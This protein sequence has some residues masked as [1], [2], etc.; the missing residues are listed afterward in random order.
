MLHPGD[1]SGFSASAYYD[2][3]QGSYIIADKGTAALI[4]WK[5]NF[6]QAF[7]LLSAQYND[8]NKL[9]LDVTQSDNAHDVIFVG[10]SLG[11]GLASLEA[12][13]T[14]DPAVTFNAAGLNSETLSRYHVS[15]DNASTLIQAYYVNGEILSTLQDFSPL[16]SAL[17]TRIPITAY[18]EP[19]I[20]SNGLQ[21]ASPISFFQRLNPMVRL[22]MH[23]EG[24]VIGS[25]YST[26]SVFGH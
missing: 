19:Q 7:G 5:A 18:G 8:A 20:T 14:G 23:S 26:S 1:G 3:N 16:P 17:G 4:D 13:K 22:N 2:D 24:W 21:V 11:G 9:A 12:L 10:H 15:D 25:L 6:S